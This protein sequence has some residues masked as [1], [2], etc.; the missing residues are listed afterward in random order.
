M[1]DL[2][3]LPMPRRG[4]RSF[5]L[6]ILVHAL[7]LWGLS[8]GLARDIARKVVPPSVWLDEPVEPPAIEPPRLDIPKP[9]FTAPPTP[10]I[11]APEI[12]IEEAA[13]SPIS[14]AVEAS[15]GP[16]SPAGSSDTSAAELPWPGP[17]ALRPEALCQVM[18]TPTVPAVNWSGRA[19]FRVHARL[20]AG[21]VAEVQFLSTAGGPDNR[22]RRALQTAVQSALGAYQC[23]GNQAFVQ[24]FVFNIH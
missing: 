8:S 1:N 14:V 20:Q 23:R 3:P 16:A 13:P 5:G 9:D 12:L 21:R 19:S 6:V 24:E 17:D 2:H 15:P 4:F 22:T 10:V 18:V 7:I 11:P